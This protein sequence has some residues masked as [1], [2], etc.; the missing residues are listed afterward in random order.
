MQQSKLPAGTVFIAVGAVLG[1]FF[2]AVLL[3]RGLTVWALKRNMR[4]AAERVKTGGNAA[5][6]TKQLLNFRRPEVPMGGYREGNRDSMLSL[7][8]MPGG[9][10]TPGRGGRPQTAS[11]TQGHASTLFFSP[12][13]QGAGGMQSNR[14]ST[15]LPSGYYAA[16][17]AAPGNGASMTHLGGNSNISLSNLGGP[18]TQGYARA[19]SLVG[20]TPPDSPSHRAMGDRL[21]PGGTGGNFSTSTL[22]LNQRPTGRA[23]SAYLE[24]LFD[25]AGA[26]P[27]NYPLNDSRHPNYNGGRF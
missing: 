27:G 1:A 26:T 14:G 20:E 9:S 25:E 24:D 18:P 17:S 5:G 16:G 7:G 2:L 10:R 21:A 22:D 3:W 12:T 6:D 4:R 11:S 19:R 8:R 23:P 15:Y 13:A